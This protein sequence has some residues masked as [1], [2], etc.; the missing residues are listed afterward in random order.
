MTSVGREFKVPLME[1]VES[2]FIV[3]VF[4]CS[5]MFIGS[6]F[7][8]LYLRALDRILLYI[9]IYICVCVC[10]VKS[11]VQSNRPNS[12]YSIKLQTKMF[13]LRVGYCIIVQLFIKD[14]SN[15]FL[16]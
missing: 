16:G 7:F 10:I 2:M 1:L 6:K 8:F 11:F 12:L 13:K 3:F 14:S 15:Y 4:S 9:Y 5:K